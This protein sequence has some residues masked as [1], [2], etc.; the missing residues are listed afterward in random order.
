MNAVVWALSLF[1]GLGFLIH[2]SSCLISPAMS[3]EFARYGLS[4]QRILVG[5]LQLCGGVGL[6]AGL[7]YVPLAIVSAGG[8]SLLMI[9]GVAVRIKIG[10]RIV[11]MLP[12]AC[13]ALSNLVLL[14]LL[15]R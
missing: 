5:L 3:R 2:G 1:N 10:D 15:S 4:R 13:Y 12:A 7:W 11:Q 14:V 9:M 6:I 8:L